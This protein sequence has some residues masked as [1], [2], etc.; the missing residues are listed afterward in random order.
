MKALTAKEKAKIEEEVTYDLRF[1]YAEDELG[2]WF[3]DSTIK[4]VL[5]IELYDVEEDEV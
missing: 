3:D 1:D 2:F 5:R 4:G